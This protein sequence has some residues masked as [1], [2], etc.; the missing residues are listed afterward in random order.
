M[1]SIGLQPKSV[2]H[3]VCSTWGG[4]IG[5][6]NFDLLLAGSLEFSLTIVAFLLE[7]CLGRMAKRRKKNSNS[8]QS[9]TDHLEMWD[10]KGPWK[11]LHHK[12][13]ER[14]KKNTWE[15]RKQ[16]MEKEVKVS[17]WHRIFLTGTCAFPLE[18][19]TV[20]VVVPNSQRHLVAASQMFNNNTKSTFGLT[21]F[22]SEPQK[23]CSC[24]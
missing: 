18:V 12:R 8:F 24:K 2:G 21:N 1:P 19:T 14:V 17:H 9:G 6:S 5:T 23:S 3:T 16:Q 20:Y 13:K 15:N 7:N 11:R 10:V 22:F 4:S